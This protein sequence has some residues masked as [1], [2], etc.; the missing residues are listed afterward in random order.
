MDEPAHL[1]TTKA[2]Y[3]TVAAD[4]ARLLPD[5]R[6]EAALDQAMLARFAELTSVVGRGHVADLGCGTGRI[7]GHLVSKQ[8][9]P[10]FQSAHG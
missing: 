6:A 3:D 8:D 2:T 9:P 5:L 10:P 4:Y 7:T 1:H